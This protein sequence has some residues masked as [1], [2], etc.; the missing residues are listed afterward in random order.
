MYAYIH[1]Y[2][3]TCIDIA[4]SLYIC[5]YLYKY[6]YV[7]IYMFV[8]RYTHIH[9]Y[10]CIRVYIYRIW[11]LGAA[12]EERGGVPQEH[13]SFHTF[14]RVPPSVT[15]SHYL[16][17]SLPLSLSRVCVRE[18]QDLT[19]QSS[20]RRAIGNLA[21][22]VHNCTCNCN[23]T[24]TCNFSCS[25][26][27]SYQTWHTRTCEMTTWWMSRVTH[28]HHKYVTWQHYTRE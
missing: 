23:C 25:C 28:T 9:L 6:I 16:F 5:L 3:Y 22:C 15:L 18:M 21:R 4:I 26:N 14:S 2:I 10:L 12:Q 7:Y 19:T 17:L 24:Y 11:Q 13:S 1:M 20:S 27:W 8:Y